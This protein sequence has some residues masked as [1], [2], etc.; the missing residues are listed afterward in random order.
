MINLLEA[1]LSPPKSFDDSSKFNVEPLKQESKEFLDEYFY[2]LVENNQQRDTL[3]DNL[4]IDYVYYKSRYCMNENEEE[5][6]KEFE[7]FSDI[8]SLLDKLDFEVEYNSSFYDSK[9]IE[10][11]WTWYDDCDLTCDSTL[12]TD[13]L[14]HCHVKNASLESKQQ[15]DY[16]KFYKEKY[17]GLGNYHCIAALD[18]LLNQQLYYLYKKD[19]FIHKV[20][21]YII[22]YT[23]SFIDLTIL[24][25]DLGDAKYLDYTIE[26]M[27]IYFTKIDDMIVYDEINASNKQLIVEGV[28]YKLNLFLDN[29]T[30]S[31]QHD[32]VRE[33]LQSKIDESQVKLNKKLNIQK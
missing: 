29:F 31:E 27:S 2:N 20:N 8:A 18:E 32:S 19:D 21:D 26:S 14:K 9:D 7:C 11:F 17:N 28:F 23:Q 33:L 1:N 12:I 22:Q 16:I 13:E 30:F 15:L 24:R 3:E 10:N 5:V 6:E 4:I 25:S